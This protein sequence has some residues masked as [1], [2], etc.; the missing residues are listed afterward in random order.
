VHCLH[1]LTHNKQPTQ[2][3][4]TKQSGALRGAG[5]DELHQYLT[6]PEAG[7]DGDAGESHYKPSKLLAEAKEKAA[8][9]QG[10]RPVLPVTVL[11]G[12]LGAGKTTMLKHILQNQ[13]GWKVSGSFRVPKSHCS[14][15]TKGRWITLSLVKEEQLT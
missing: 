11:S 5:W 6:G 7:H 4:N 12:F 13:E 14:C 8:A 3:N 1:T 15:Q 10:E 9:A 2:T